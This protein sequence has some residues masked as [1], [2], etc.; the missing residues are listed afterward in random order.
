MTG[1]T[2]QVGEG[3]PNPPRLMAQARAALALHP[4][5]GAHAKQSGQPCLGYAMR[6]GRCYMHG[7]RRTLSKRAQARED[8]ATLKAI[9][10]WLDS[11]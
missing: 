1:V 9:K 3:A 4:R 6:N 8:R 2:D 10:E 5:C 11:V 7:G